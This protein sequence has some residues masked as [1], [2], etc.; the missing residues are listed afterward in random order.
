MPHFAHH[1]EE[2][3]L[4]AIYKLSNKDIKKLNNVALSKHM[5]LNPATVLEMIRKMADKKLV[6]LLGDKT[7]Q[8]TEKGEKT[9][10]LIIRK[11]RLWE[12]FL[13][14]KLKYKWNEVHD[15]AEQL[16]HIESEDMINRLEEFLGF[17]AHDPHGDAIPDKNG[18]IKEQAVI[19]LLNG[20]AGKRYLI[21][22]FAETDD[23]FLDYLSQLRIIPGTKIKMIEIHSYDQSCTIEAHKTTIQLSEKVASN[24][25]VTLLR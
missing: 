3:Y 20:E 11:H 21:S 12:V 4:K 10:L 22:H 19:A 15:L 18:K 17:P 5:G 8:L 24:I 25:L 1:F 16:E 14:N 23:A 6:H 13:V 7:I 2:N 9:A